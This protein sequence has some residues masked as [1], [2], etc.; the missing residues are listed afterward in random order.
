MMSQCR[1][2]SPQHHWASPSLQW[3]LS[4]ETFRFF[5]WYTRPSL[6]ARSASLENAPDD[7]HETATDRIQSSIASDRSTVITCCWPIFLV[8]SS[9]PNSV[10]AGIIIRFIHLHRQL[11][12]NL[13]RRLQVAITILDYNYKRVRECINSM[14]QEHI[15][16][17]LLPV[18]TAGSEQLCIDEYPLALEFHLQID[19][20]L[21]FFLRWSKLLI[22][23]KYSIESFLHEDVLVSRCTPFS[24]QPSWNLLCQS[25]SQWTVWAVYRWRVNDQ[26]SLVGSNPSLTRRSE[27]SRRKHS[28]YSTDQYGSTVSGCLRGE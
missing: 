10:G 14:A 20:K 27:R 19:S 15:R 25:L 5:A 11:Y 28:N 12:G 17:G 8:K 2:P 22:A 4:N 13:A 6:Y 16:H 24:P 23:C 3:T 1:L 26:Q 18:T 7:I 9:P 21:F